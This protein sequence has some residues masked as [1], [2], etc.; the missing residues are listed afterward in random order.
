VH[1]T[2]SE[3]SALKRDALGIAHIVFFVVAAAAPL[4]AIIGGAPLAFSL[5][6]GAGAPAAYVIAGLVYL[7]FSA[8]FVAMSRY[9][10]SAGAFYVFVTR[11]LGP[12]WGLAAGAMTVLTYNAIQLAAY[13]WFG[14]VLGGLAAAAGL[15][16]P[17]WACTFACILAVDFC[18][19][20][21]IE[22]TGGILGV[23][24]LGEVTVLTIL[25]LCILAQ[26]GGPEGITLKSFA[27]AQVFSPGLGISLLF[28][29]ASFLG[30]EATVIFAEEARDRLRTIPRATYVAVLLITLFY[31]FS[32]WCMVVAYGPALI[33]SVANAD[34][35][36]L[37]MHTAAA[38][39]GHALQLVMTAFLVTSLF[40][41]VLSF[42][43]TISR[44]LFAWGREGLLPRALGRVHASYQSPI[45]ACRTQSVVAAVAIG[46]G[47]L[48]RLDPYTVLYSWL[49]AASAIGILTVQILVCLSVVAFFSRNPRETTLWDRLW[50]PLL[51]GA[52][53]A[54]ILLLALI[55][56]PMLA[57]SGS[58]LVW[59]LPGA[60]VAAAFI[61]V[62]LPAL[63]RN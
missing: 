62:A 13:A 25:N 42:Q 63:R 30:F 21:N 46:A 32:A 52:G 26:G 22:F 54:A 61:G 49:A 53:L 28:A 58:W 20:R 39:G 51:S 3:N 23:C 10:G 31:S 34:L 59:T 17:W 6:N 40:A 1:M 36:D 56:L 24:M 48:L 57:G 12:T 60:F 44:Y 50:A 18:A 45:V 38:R 27:P 35:A 43:S 4:T 15:V 11:G 47:A 33:K 16:L 41:C 37:F 8:G 55:N 7:M 14:S 29:V 19:S 2:S 5:G 9:V